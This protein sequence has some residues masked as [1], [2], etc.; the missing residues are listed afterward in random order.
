V[1]NEYAELGVHAAPRA[2]LRYITER[3]GDLGFRKVISAVL[4][5]VVSLG[6]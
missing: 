5:A 6:L 3:E 1:R 2:R 4:M